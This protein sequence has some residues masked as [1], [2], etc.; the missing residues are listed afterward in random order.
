MQDSG[1]RDAVFY[2][3]MTGDNSNLLASLVGYYES[4][5]LNNI[6]FTSR[7]G[8]VQGRG[9]KPEKFGD[10]KL[11][12]PFTR[13]MLESRKASWDM[14]IGK[15]GVTLKFGSPVFSSDEFLGFVGYGYFIDQAFL[16]SIKKVINAELFYILK[17]DS[18]L[19]ASTRGDIEV[20]DFDANRLNNSLEGENELEREREVASGYHAVGYIPVHQ[21]FSFFF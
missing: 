7:D 16:E 4:L 5:D 15:N 2:K 14:E 1:L 10:S 18:Q 17:K 8:I 13:T 19:I 9:H 20:A 6:E 21:A 3:T 11:D 12:F